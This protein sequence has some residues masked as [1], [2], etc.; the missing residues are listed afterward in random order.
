[1]NTAR[2]SRIK[3]MPSGAMSSSLGLAYSIIH[4]GPRPTGV[5]LS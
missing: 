5:D 2:R 4:L 1:M 3:T